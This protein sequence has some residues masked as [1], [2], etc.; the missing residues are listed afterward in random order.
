MQ[1]KVTVRGSANIIKQEPFK[2]LS[3]RFLEF[4]QVLKRKEVDVWL[5]SS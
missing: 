4:F 2:N 1:M 5:A 3:K